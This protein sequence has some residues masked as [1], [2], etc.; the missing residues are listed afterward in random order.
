MNTVVRT[1][2]TGEFM[3]QSHFREVNVIYTF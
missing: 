2:I 1:E 3:E